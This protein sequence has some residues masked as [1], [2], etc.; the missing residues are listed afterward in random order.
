MRWLLLLGL[1]FVF[2]GVLL[3]INQIPT[4]KEENQ[5]IPKPENY[6]LVK[7]E[8]MMGTRMC[9][10][11]WINGEK[12]QYDFASLNGMLWLEDG[13]PKPFSEVAEFENRYLAVN[14]EVKNY[15]LILECWS[16]EG[17]YNETQQVKA[18][19]VK[20]WVNAAYCESDADCVPAECCH[21]SACVNKEFAPDCSNVYCT[22]EC[23]PGTMDCGQGYCACVNHT[24]QAIIS[25]MK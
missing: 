1:A 5:T 14:G 7:V 6:T 20:Q 21:P 24:C 17:Y 10:V 4:A 2:V 18:I 16:P 8:R 12:V 9:P 13:K 23:R 11:A 15:T 22:M 19:E 25:T 3:W